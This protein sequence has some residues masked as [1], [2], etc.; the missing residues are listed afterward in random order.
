LCHG[1]KKSTKEN[2]SV[3]LSGQ[4]AIEEVQKQAIDKLVL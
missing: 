2:P 1:N 4:L 3:I